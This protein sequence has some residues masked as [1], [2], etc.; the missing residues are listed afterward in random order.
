MNSTRWALCAALFSCLALGASGCK[1]DQAGAADAPR[2]VEK[3]PGIETADPPAAPATGPGTSPAAGEPAAQS[4]TP[5]ADTP[6]KGGAV[7]GSHVVALGSGGKSKVVGV[8][9][10][11]IADTPTYTVTL[12][13]PAQVGKGA[14]ATATV[15]ILP[16]EGWKLNKEFPTKLTITEPAGVKVAK[17]E[18]T[19]A[20][21]VAFAEK[22]GKWSVEFQADS[23]GGKDFT[24]VVK[25]AVCTE[26]SCDPKKQ[27]LAWNVAVGD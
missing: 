26:T 24:A 1:Q 12:A 5:P 3:L 17:K 19:V 7:E 16:K 2:P 15:E 10:R 4:T 6:S 11:T 25:F 14:Q 21:A 22:S 13:A 18:Q 20:D 27:E 8:G 9:A 23:T